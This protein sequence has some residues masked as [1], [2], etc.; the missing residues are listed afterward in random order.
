MVKLSNEEVIEYIENFLSDKGDPWDWDDFTSI[1]IEDNFLNEISL[2]S[3]KTHVNYPPIDGKGY[4]SEEG[5]EYMRT[6]IQKI[7][8]R[9]Y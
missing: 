3:S 1:P 5:C 2:E 8:D 7:K 6:L 4:C 9:N